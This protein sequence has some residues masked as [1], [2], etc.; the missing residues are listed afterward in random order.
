VFSKDGKRIS[1]D[2]VSETMI[3]LVHSSRVGEEVLRFY[4]DG[5]VAIESKTREGALDKLNC[6][7]LCFR[8][9]RMASVYIPSFRPEELCA[10]KRNPQW[11]LTPK[12]AN[13][14]E[15]MLSSGEVVVIDP[16]PEYT[17]EEAKYT[18]FRAVFMMHGDWRKDFTPLRIV[19]TDELEV[20]ANL[21]DRTFR[22]H[23]A[24]ELTA[25]MEAWTMRD[26][27]NWNMGFILSWICIERMMF[28]QIMAAYG[29]SAI[30][31]LDKSGR[32]REIT[33]YEAIAHLKSGLVSGS[34]A[35]L[36]DDKAA[37][38]CAY[39]D[40]VQEMR[41]IRNEIVH[42]D[43]RATESEMNDCFRAATTAMWR[44]FRLAGIQDYSDYLAMMQRGNPSERLSKE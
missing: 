33:S 25:F 30:Y 22:S 24:T 5:F 20:A 34:L 3:E 10:I 37:F 40:R 36:P 11:L 6:F 39:L 2:E 23:M 15:E 9:L 1:P 27:M 42:G 19:S 43:R 32:R 28:N 17:I 21:A 8:L 14:T 26:E 38:D 7:L 16:G 4:K 13:E 18:S 31:K 44:M 41:G 35:F 12:S 29:D